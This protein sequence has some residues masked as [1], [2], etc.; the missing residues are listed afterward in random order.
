MHPWGDDPDNKAGCAYANGADL[1][2]NEKLDVQSRTTMDCRDGEVYT[3][4]VG[5]F[6]GNAFG[7]HDMI[8]NAIEWV[9]DCLNE[10]YQGAP[11][12]GSTWT[13][14][15]CSQRMLRGGSWFVPLEGLR[16]PSAL[17][18]TKATRKTTSV[19][20]LP[21]RLPLRILLLWVSKGAKPL[22]R[23]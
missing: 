4:P 8:G 17:R 6:R 19:S 15:V 13:G 22:P 11:A 5:S 1:T 23:L 12:D 16:R 9:E 14:G 20:E 21:G 2:A 10:S 7:L 3:A 18:T